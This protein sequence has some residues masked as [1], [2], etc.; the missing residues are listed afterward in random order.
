M[1]I[2]KDIELIT[3][4]HPTWRKVFFLWAEVQDDLD[5]SFLKITF[6][7]FIQN[8]RL[9]KQDIDIQF[10]QD[11]AREDNINIVESFYDKI[12]S[13]LHEKKK[14]QFI[15]SLK[16]ST[17][18]HLFDQYVEEEIHLLLNNGIKIE[19]LKNQFFNKLA[20][21][22][23]SD[24]LFYA[25]QEFREQSMNWNIESYLDIIKKNNLDVAILPSSKNT[26]MI[27]VLNYK[28]CQFIGSHSW[29]IVSMESMYDSYTKN[30]NRQFIFLDFNL[31]VE[32][33]KSMIGITVDLDGFISSSHLKDD[34]STDENTRK[35]FDF[36]QL[37]NKEV[38]SFIDQ[39]DDQDGFELA[40]KF[41]ITEC[42]D[43]FLTM[44]HI[45]LTK[46]SNKILYDAFSSNNYDL[47]IKLLKTD[48]L[49]S[50]EKI[51]N[52]I[53]NPPNSRYS[54]GFYSHGRLA[55]AND[56]L[57]IDSTNHIF[58]YLKFFL[59][60][61]RNK[62]NTIKE[63]LDLNEINPSYNNNYAIKYAIKRQYFQII[64][65]L[66][67]ETSSCFGEYIDSLILL[68]VQAKNSE[69]ILTLMNDERFD[70]E[71]F[72]SALFCLSIEHNNEFVIQLL[73]KNSEI[74]ITTYANDLLIWA[75]KY[76]HYF[77]LMDLLSRRF[78]VESINKNWVLSNISKD[79]YYGMFF[80][81]MDD[82]KYCNRI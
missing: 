30:L 45:K 26:L 35:L 21:F 68:A 49:G 65:L 72:K 52:D 61:E 80:K 24:E 33:N 57:K 47:C 43:N 7:L 15:N 51:I 39:T 59:S 38:I 5:I 70:L 18:E 12:Q 75:V 40:I 31:P 34:E 19:V 14:E 23:Y 42:I 6:A 8:K 13:V 82:L 44:P 54:I 32:D 64:K 48:R 22:Y 76:D 37:S 62:I 28:A 9:L 53:L 69:I 58:L 11:L 67:E 56:L 46:K 55:A 1:S 66:I 78:I 74:D 3:Q 36:E 79:S 20:R 27:R 71:S 2:T 10:A 50:Q 73:I 60:I 81:A 25:L 16:T 17:Y 29:C 63:M 4:K 41:N 77:I